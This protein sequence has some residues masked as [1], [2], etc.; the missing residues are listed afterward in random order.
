MP[1]L[2][3]WSRYLI[4][5]GIAFPIAALSLFVGLRAWATGRSKMS[6]REIELIDEHGEEYIAS[7]TS[8]SGGSDD[9]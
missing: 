7:K 5:I 2:I 4:T 9:S 6:E 8:S 3:G 1:R